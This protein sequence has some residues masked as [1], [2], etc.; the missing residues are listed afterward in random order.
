M[1][2][3]T[4]RDLIKKAMQKIG[5]L[6]DGEEPSSSEANDCFDAL[7]LMLESWAGRS[8][9]T[10]AQIQEG[11]TLTASQSSYTI[12]SGGNFNTTK[13]F[14]IES[15]FIRDS[16]NTDYPIVVISK[17]VYNGYPDK[18]YTT[19][20]SRPRTLFYDP[21]LTQQATQTGTV[22][23]YP[24]PDSSTTYTLY[25]NSEKPFTS[26]TNL[27]STVTFP[28]GYKRAIIYNLALEICPDFNKTASA[29]LQKTAAQSMK[30]VENIN[31]KN[32]KHISTVDLPGTISPYNPLSD[33]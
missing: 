12:G 20:T 29:E 10:S 25:I 30:I 8:L 4:A 6:A 31:S 26:F 13:P 5:I 27:S 16:N 11:F 3:S 33:E 21:G 28:T 18:A 23:L 2:T 1:S 7:N 32:K 14:S 15:A 24:I 17:D 9:L 19:S 22:Y